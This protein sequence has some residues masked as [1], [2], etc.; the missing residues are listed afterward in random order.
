METVNIDNEPYIFQ[1]CLKGTECAI[2]YRGTD[3]ITE[4]FSYCY[5]KLPDYISN[6]ATDFTVHVSPILD[7][8]KDFFDQFNA[9]VIATRVKNGE[10]TVYGNKCSFDWLVFGKI[11]ETE[12]EPS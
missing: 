7:D 11:L 12:D 2:Y 9:R 10:F 6:L 5:I 1:D 3:E 4:N 8:T